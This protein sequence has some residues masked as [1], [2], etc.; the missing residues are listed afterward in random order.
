MATPRVYADFQNVDDRNRV[1]LTC[2]GTLHDLARHGIA[3]REGLV[4]T[5]YS[6]DAA[7]DGRPDELHADGTVRFDEEQDI[8]VATIDWAAVRHAS[9]D[10]SHTPGVAV[11]RPAPPTGS[12]RRPGRRAAPGTR[13]G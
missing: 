6:D 3:L 11:T 1:R 7:E 8:W 10:T 4:F 13:T 9:D 5:F 2:A 12:A